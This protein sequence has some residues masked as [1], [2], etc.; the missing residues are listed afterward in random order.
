VQRAAEIQAVDPLTAY[1]TRMCAVQ[2]GIKIPQRHADISALI[3]KVMAEMEASK[4]GLALGGVESDRFHVEALALRVFAGAD[5]L[6][7]A[8][9]R[10]ETTKKRYFAAK[11]FFQ[12]RRGRV[13]G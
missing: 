3:G 9:R 12:V 11:V 1:Y 7:R 10:D 5:K 13:G 6:D 8:G 4:P 2:E